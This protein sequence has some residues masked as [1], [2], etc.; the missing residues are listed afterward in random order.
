MNKRRSLG[1]IIGFL[2]CL[3]GLAACQGVLNIQIEPELAAPTAVLGKVAH[4]T[5]GD[6]WVTDLDTGEKTR[7]T[8][9][10]RNSYPLWSADGQWLA[11]FKRD[12]LWLRATNGSEEQRLGAFPV[13][14][15][16][17]SPTENRLAYLTAA[18][19]L[20]VWNAADGTTQTL[21]TP[22]PTT[23]L[24]ALAWRPDGQ[25]LAYEVRGVAWSLNVIALDGT[26][27]QTRY[28]A[29]EAQM[30]PQLG[31]WSPDGRVL[32]TWL[33]PTSSPYRENGL[34]LCMI[35]ESADEQPH[36]LKERVL[37]WSDF[38]DWS[39]THQIAFIGGAGRETWVNKGL[40][41]TDPETLVPRWL[42]GNT[43][44]AP[45]QPSWSP[46]GNR[47]VYSAGPVTPVA[48]ADEQ[49]DSALAQRRIWMV[50]VASGLRNQL[51]GD[52]RYRDERPLWA[53]DGKHI[54]FARLSASEASLWL[55]TADGRSLE[56][57]VAELTPQPDPV[58]EYGYIQWQA[59]WDW[60]QPTAEE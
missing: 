6:I 35:P 51:T 12:E 55:M 38:V 7:L 3:L 2:V 48:L 10:G 45:L 17:W 56:Q 8:R 14:D 49:R 40:A 15:F 9:D 41:I 57:V 11:Y 39:A 27:L 44:Q 5:G 28:V 1:K 47:I 25:A 13:Q 26:A 54:L 31:G 50:Q 58:G 22:D 19:G 59:L 18:A 16:A 52:G 42:V 37:P 21:V 43:E 33:G 53:N 23:T 4:I 20:T 29:R 30:I 34:P 60:W 46:Q 32:L 36:C 24:I